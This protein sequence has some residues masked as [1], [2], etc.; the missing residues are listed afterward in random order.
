MPVNGLVAHQGRVLTLPNP[1][2]TVSFTVGSI[3][4]S[5]NKKHAASMQC[6]ARERARTP[7][8]RVLYGIHVP[9][10]SNCYMARAGRPGD[11]HASEVRSVGPDHVFTSWLILKDYSRQPT[12]TQECMHTETGIPSNRSGYIGASSTPDTTH[13]FESLCVSS[14]LDIWS[15]AVLCAVCCGLCYRCCHLIS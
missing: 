3:Q 9:R 4:Q 8:Y 15:S 1:K 11:A 2:N 12:H 13:N 6:S 5:T 14:S 10:L 7:V